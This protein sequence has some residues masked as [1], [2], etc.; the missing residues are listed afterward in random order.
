MKN[1]KLVKEENSHFTVH[2]GKE[3]FP[4]AKHMLDH[5]LN[6]KIRSLPKY[7]EGGE[8]D[9]GVDDSI[10]K[11]SSWYEK[12]GYDLMKDSIKDAGKPQVSAER[13]KQAMSNPNDSFAQNYPGELKKAAEY[14][15]MSAPQADTVVP[16]AAPV[17]EEQ[18]PV[19]PFAQR[20]PSSENAGLV[21]PPNQPIAGQANAKPAPQPQIQNP[22]AGMQ[23]SM[24]NN[25]KMIESGAIAQAKA[26]I[27]LAKQQAG[28]L[29]KQFT[30]E[31]TQDLHNRLKNLD[32]V[33]AKY[34]AEN[35]ALMQS[36]A[37][38]KTDPN[39]LW[40]EKSTGGKI[41]AVI[42][43]LLGGAGAHATGGR[44]IA[45]D[46]LNEQIK[47]DIDS[48]VNDQQNKKSL[49]QMNL[50]RLHDVNSARQATYLQLNSA[51]QGQLQAAS[52]KAQGQLAQGA[53]QQ[54]LGQLRNQYDTNAVTLKQQA[55][56]MA[57]KQ[58]LAGG[59]SSG[60][61]LEYLDKDTRERVVR[62]PMGLR[63]A[64][65]K[66]DAD[67]MKKNLTSLGTLN[68]TIDGMQKTASSSNIGI[69]LPGTGASADFDSS[70]A[71]ILTELNKLQDLNRLTDNEMH[72]FEKMVPSSSEFF[73]AKGMAKLS[74]L[75][76][77]INTSM[78]QHFAEHLEG[79]NY[80]PNATPAKGVR[81]K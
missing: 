52:S 64:P 27:D 76:E 22:M 31:Q 58:A 13:V 62:T 69:H 36:V 80:L 14:Y 24:A 50:E 41:M 49:Y 38:N 32:A 56:G 26:Q 77:M 71:S 2:D 55:M 70:R 47:Q 10:P 44:N 60:T 28:I 8:V 57:A 48:Q 45:L 75:K 61:S 23:A 42:G 59:Q 66:E 63:M 16:D 54:T 21:V 18:V 72:Q 11:E 1:Y 25:E 37:A 33:E 30:P 53:L 29:D 39:R 74:K 73:S 78:N 67:L 19:Q 34:G 68:S 15:G 81:K 46:T 65:T 51:V 12:S 6:Q 20:A 40:N 9:P 5:S 4:I 3:S 35:Q 79:N 7:A 43:L 17:S